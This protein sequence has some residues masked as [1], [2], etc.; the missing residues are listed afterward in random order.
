MKKILLLL[1]VIL[2]LSMPSFAADWYWVCSKNGG[3]IYIDNSSVQKT[4][5]YAVIWSKLDLP[6]GDTMVSQIFVNRNPKSWTLMDAA[7]YRDGL[8]ISSRTY[9]SPN[10]QNIRPGDVMDNIYDLIW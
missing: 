6:N 8:C 2:S 3:S 9:N 4:P 5:E 10:W 1:L 7:I